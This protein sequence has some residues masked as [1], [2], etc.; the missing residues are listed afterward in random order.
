MA[1]R[2]QFDE[3]LHFPTF[4]WSRLGLSFTRCCGLQTDAT[5]K[6]ATLNL[7]SS[8]LA[9]LPTFLVFFPPRSHDSFPLLPM[10][11]WTPFQSFH[12]YIYVF[13]GEERVCCE[14]CR[15]L[16]AGRLYWLWQESPPAPG[17]VLQGLSCPQAQSNQQQSKSGTPPRVGW[18]M[19]GRDIV[20]SGHLQLTAI[21]DTTHGGWGGKDLILSFLYFH[22]LRVFFLKLT[23]CFVCGRFEGQREDFKRKKLV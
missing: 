21:N 12:E 5:T 14:G 10:A 16:C 3:L 8:F 4:L 1:E 11:L 2:A 20:P 15:A 17:R 6:R 22:S 13:A 19:T 9:F 23:I 18:K 7:R